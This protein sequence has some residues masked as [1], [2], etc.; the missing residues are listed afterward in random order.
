MDREL[1]GT[2]EPPLLS[3]AE[4]GAGGWGMASLAGC[5]EGSWGFVQNGAGQSVLMD[6][7]SNIMDICC[8]LE[9][10]TGKGCLQVYPL[11]TH[12]LK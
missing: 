12:V 11:E 10:E 7:M 9:R 4:W 3:G 6:Q 1:E 2:G 5:G 8:L